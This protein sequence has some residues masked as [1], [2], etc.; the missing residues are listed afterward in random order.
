MSLAETLKTATAGAEHQKARFTNVVVI[1][2]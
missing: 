2:G 1:K